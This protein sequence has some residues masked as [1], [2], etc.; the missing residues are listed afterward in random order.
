MFAVLFMLIDKNEPLSIKKSD[1]FVNCFYEHDLDLSKFEV[2]VIP[3]FA[4]TKT[5]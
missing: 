3:V 4:I 1:S 5:L 2:K